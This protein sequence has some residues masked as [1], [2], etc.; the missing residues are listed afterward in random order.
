MEPQSGGPPAHTRPRPVAVVRGGV[1]VDPRRPVRA[2]IPIGGDVWYAWL[3]APENGAFRVESSEGGFTARRERR[4][5]GAYWYA[6][7]HR[8]GRRFKLYLGPD[9]ALTPARLATAARRLA[10]PS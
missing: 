9:R 6:V 5:G 1:L 3:A 8:G 10:G 2:A 4:R 7:A